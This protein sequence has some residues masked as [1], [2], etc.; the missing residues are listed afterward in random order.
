MGCVL[1]PLQVGIK[2]VQGVRVK[3]ASSAAFS[4]IKGRSC[5]SVI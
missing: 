4:T 1:A 3:R 2:I 5:M